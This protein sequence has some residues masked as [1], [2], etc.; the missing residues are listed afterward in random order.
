MKTEK[1]GYTTLYSL[2]DLKIKR[3]FINRMYNQHILS[4]WPTGY[5]NPCTSLIFCPYYICHYF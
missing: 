1:Y 4:S 5:K 2:N 3:S